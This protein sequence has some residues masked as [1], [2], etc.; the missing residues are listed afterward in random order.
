MASAD[1]AAAVTAFEMALLINVGV[2]GV[3]LQFISAGPLDPLV[4]RRMFKVINFFIF[5]LLA[6]MGTSWSSLGR[7][8]LATFGLQAINVAM[9]MIADR[10]VVIAANKRSQ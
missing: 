10:A 3:L 6:T 8:L 7:F 5:G 1:A 4:A 9:Q 2:N